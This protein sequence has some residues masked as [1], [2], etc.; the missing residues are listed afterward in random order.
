MALGR[1]GR[2]WSLGED[3][4][5]KDRG[6]W[7]ALAFLIQPGGAEWYR[8]ERVKET[9]P[10]PTLH[11][12]TCRSG[13]SDGQAETR[14]AVGQESFVM[15]PLPLWVSSLVPLLPYLS[16]ECVWELPDSVVL[17]Q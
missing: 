14:G 10:G 13:Q 9:P 7:T 6:H 12:L 1:A 2:L 3:P 5:P 15:P 8:K 4:S 17:A 16:P 11:L